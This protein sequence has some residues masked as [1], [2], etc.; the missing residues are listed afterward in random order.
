MSRKPKSSL[1][2]SLQRHRDKRHVVSH[3]HTTDFGSSSGQT[4]VSITE[5]SSLD[6]F[7][8]NAEAA[9]RSFEA[10]RHVRI[11][12]HEDEELDDV[13]EVSEDEDDGDVDEATFCTIPKKPNWRDMD[14]P[15]E[16]QR[17]EELQFLAWKKKLNKLQNKYPKLPPFEK[18]L[19]FWRQLWKIVEISDVV[20]QVVDARD[21]IFYFSQDL[22]DYVNEVSLAKQSVLLVNK[23]DFLTREQRRQWAEYFVDSDLKTFFFSA[24]GDEDEK[25]SDPD[26]LVFNTARILS[27]PEVLEALQNVV[28]ISPLTVGFLGYPNVGKS[29]TI[30]RFLTNKRLQV[31]ATPGKTKHYQTHVLKGE[32]KLVDGPGLVIPNLNMT[33]ADMVLA[34]ILPIDHLTDYTPSIELLLS[35]I[36]YSFVLKHYGIMESCVSAARKADR[37]NPALQI[38]SAFGLMRGFMKPGGIP[39][40]FKAAKIILRDY[41]QGK[42][43]FCQAPPTSEQEE[44]FSLNVDESAVRDDEDMALEESFPELQLQSGVHVRG[45]IGSQPLVKGKKGAISKKRKEKARRIYKDVDPYM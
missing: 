45:K 9:Q 18:N 17:T 22:S 28:P 29:S 21:P 4:V 37:K 19:E 5:N 8:T 14:S 38:L 27:P 20:V 35:R 3:R 40:Q 33:K 42:L 43:L 30:N 41:V 31:S 12:R 23:A 16:F 1:G 36:P 44:Y 26:N 39:D 32:I 11:V 10:E 2:R 15:E 34:G 7:L 24:T 6:E 25:E 13:D